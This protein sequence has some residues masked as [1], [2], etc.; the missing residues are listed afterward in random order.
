VRIAK[1]ATG[2]V[3]ERELLP[4]AFVPMVSQ[5]FLTFHIPNFAF[6]FHKWRFL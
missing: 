4:V 6:A 3:T 1:D 2:E 5:H